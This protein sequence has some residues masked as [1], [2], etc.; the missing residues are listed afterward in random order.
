MERWFHLEELP[1]LYPD[2]ENL[3]RYSPW[4]KLHAEL[5]VPEKDSAAA[6]QEG[7]QGVSLGGPRRPRCM[8]LLYP[9]LPMYPLRGPRRRDAEAARRHLVAIG[10]YEVQKIL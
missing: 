8:E 5:C 9:V 2:T 4:Y 1:D 3:R 7:T 6:V 10:V